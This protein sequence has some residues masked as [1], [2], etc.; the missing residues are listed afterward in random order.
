[1]IKFRLHFCSFFYGKGPGKR[2]QWC[3]S[4]LINNLERQSIDY[5]KATG[6]CLRERP[7]STG[8]GS[9]L[10]CSRIKGSSS[11]PH[12]RHRNAQKPFSPVPSRMSEQKSRTKRPWH[13][14]H[15]MVESKV[16]LSDFRECEKFESFIA[17]VGFIVPSFTLHSDMC[18][19]WHELNSFWDSFKLPSFNL[20]V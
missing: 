5:D 18:T 3:F 20:R 8:W 1:M 15:V 9:E 17:L 13:R 10:R 2:A 4:T 19:Q 12:W 11:S 14:W 7:E 6:I 16:L